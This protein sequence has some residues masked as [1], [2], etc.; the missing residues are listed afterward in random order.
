M[1]IVYC[2]WMEFAIVCWSLLVYDCIKTS[3]EYDNVNSS[4]EWKSE[5]VFKWHITHI[6]ASTAPRMLQNVSQMCKHICIVTV[7]YIQQLHTNAIAA[8]ES[9]ASLPFQWFGSFAPKLLCHSIAKRI[10]IW[11][12]VVSVYVFIVREGNVSF[13]LVDWWVAGKL[14]IFRL[15]SCQN[16]RNKKSA[17]YFRPT[18]AGWRERKPNKT[19]D[20]RKKNVTHLRKYSTCYFVFCLGSFHSSQTF[21]RLVQW[22]QILLSLWNV[23]IAH[24]RYV[25]GSLDQTSDRITKKEKRKEK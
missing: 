15:N 9:T 24:I 4:I 3:D 7:K 19:K 6:K 17:T 14:Y 22:I 18:L 11:N 13:R 23:C 21:F 10:P 20:T 25:K 12:N 16:E 5:G 2:N 8:I 1:H